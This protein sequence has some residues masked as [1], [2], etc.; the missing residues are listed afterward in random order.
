MPLI[1]TGK[2]KFP[3]DVVLRVMREEF[4][5]FSSMYPRG[6]LKEIKLV[7]YD[8]G[9]RR[10]TVYTQATNSKF[11]TTPCCWSFFEGEQSKKHCF[12][13]GFPK[14]VKLGKHCFRAMFLKC[15]EIRKVVSMSY[16]LKWNKSQRHCFLAVFLEARQPKNIYKKLHW[17]TKGILNLLENV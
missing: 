8:Q 16:S 9:I 13:A 11:K 7:R 10:K 2:H 15:G 12:V 1:G 4:E 17:E 3:E 14:V 6:T 5:K